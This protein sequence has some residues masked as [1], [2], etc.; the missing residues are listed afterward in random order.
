ME[1][2][3]LMSGY[4]MDCQTPVKVAQNLGI[5]PPDDTTTLTALG[6]IGRYLRE[7]YD[8]LELPEILSIFH[9]RFKPNDSPYMLGVVVNIDERD[10]KF[11]E[12]P[13]HKKVKQAFMILGGLEEGDI[14]WDTVHVSRASFIEVGGQHL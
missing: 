11:E 3:F 5:Q 2:H 4:V 13:E 14:W 6:G 8:S 12:E 10:K 1:L 7:N 9:P